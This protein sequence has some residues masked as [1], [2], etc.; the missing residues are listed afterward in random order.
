MKKIKGVVIATIAIALLMTLNATASTIK[1]ENRCDPN[2][3][4]FLTVP[5][6]KNWT[7]MF[8][9]P[10]TSAYDPVNDFAEE[11]Y[12]GENLDVVVL[13]D[14]DPRYTEMYDVS[15]TWYIEQDHAKTPLKVDG[16][17]NMGNYTVLRDFIS[18]CKD[19][20]P[21][22]RYILCLYGHGLSWQGACLDEDPGY[23]R[24]PGEDYY[25][26]LTMKEMQKAISEA[27][28]VDILCFTNPCMMGVIEGMYELRDCIDVYISGESAAMWIYWLGTFDNLCKTLNE[29]PEISTI[30]LS[31][32][33]LDTINENVYEIQKNIP[34]QTSWPLRN[35]IQN[36]VG[37][38]TFTFSA[39]RTDRMRNVTESLDML[40][41]DLIQRLPHDYLKI[42]FA[43]KL[44]EY[45]PHEQTSRAP[46]L[47]ELL[48]PSQRYRRN[49]C[50]I[51][52]VGYGELYCFPILDIYDFADNCINLY[53]HSNETI[54]NHAQQVKNS[55]DDAVI[56]SHHRL[57]HKDAHGIAI[58]LPNLGIADRINL[59][60][61]VTSDL[62]FVNDSC[63]DEFLDA[64][65]NPFVNK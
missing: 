61:Y 29:Q 38:M 23:P 28:G 21:A 11:A 60:N 7:L 34:L 30:E 46:F 35:R 36:S 15:I 50:T 62:D 53:K 64:Y 22:E 27:G 25:D 42:W 44:T 65:L 37:I 17:L 41:R 2:P 55:V 6:T 56:R 5:E 59:N 31:E 1:I 54:C 39:V 47:V 40:A 45:F 32:K 63:W 9:A 12:S 16:E 3:N 48:R 19:N 20:F 33:I 57:L 24:V 13:Q 4:N 49:I 18:Y 10:E 43:S 52:G 51:F 58:F 14:P 8:Y 26:L